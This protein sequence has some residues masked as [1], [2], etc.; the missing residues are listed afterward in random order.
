MSATSVQQKLQI[1]SVNY[2]MRLMEG[3]TLNGRPCYLL[4][5][6]P[7]RRNPHSIKGKAWLDAN[8]FFLLKVEGRPTASLSF[9]IGR[10]LVMREYEDVNGLSLAHTARAW[11]E[12]LFSGRSELMIEYRNYTMAPVS[13]G[14]P[15]TAAMSEC[16]SGP[17][18]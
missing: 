2:S 16:R 12:G 10:P 4:E 17:H 15:R 5:L 6:T 7:K 11:S 14:A 8:D 18:K 1:T 3:T 9:L 13:E